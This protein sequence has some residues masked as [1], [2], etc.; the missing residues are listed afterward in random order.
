MLASAG[1]RPPP[2]KLVPILKR[3]LP[4]PIRP[5]C[6]VRKSYTVVAGVDDS[7][8]DTA[9]GFRDQRAVATKLRKF[10]EYASF[11]SDRSFQDAEA[12]S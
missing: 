12:P 1:A 7:N 3:R 11:V 5:D 6:D 8:A 10:A 9:R 2:T 4:R